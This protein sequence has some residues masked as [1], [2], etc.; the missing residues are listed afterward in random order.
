M[1]ASVERRREV[2]ALSKKYNFLI[3]EGDYL[4]ADLHHVTL[5]QKQFGLTDDPYYYLYYGTASRPPSYFSLETELQEVGRVIR[6]DSLSKVLSA[7]IRIG[8]VSG[9]EPVLRAIDTQVCLHI[10][11][12]SYTPGR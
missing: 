10:V 7:G 1:T 2:L 3:I 6:F 11:R 12:P 4:I 8:F 5:A 9:P